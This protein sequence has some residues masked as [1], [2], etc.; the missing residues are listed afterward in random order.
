MVFL[1]FL[2][3]PSRIEPVSGCLIY[4]ISGLQ[5]LSVQTTGSKY[6]ATDYFHQHQLSLEFVTHGDKIPNHRLQRRVIGVAFLAATIPA[7]VPSLVIRAAI[8]NT[9]R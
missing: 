2:V 9:R 3:I 8:F 1:F 6:F 5:S 4:Q 7:D